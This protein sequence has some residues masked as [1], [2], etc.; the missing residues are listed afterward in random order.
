[1]IGSREEEGRCSLALPCKLDAGLAC[2]TS[3]KRAPHLIHHGG[4]MTPSAKGLPGLDE[5]EKGL[6]PCSRG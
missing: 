1:M 3:A 5:I 2:E 4:E 6:A